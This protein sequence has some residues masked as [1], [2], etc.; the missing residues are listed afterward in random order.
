MFENIGGKIK[1][2]AK[3]VCWAGIIISVIAGIVMIVQGSEINNSYYSRGAG[4]SL[5][6]GGLMT[7]IIGS[8]LSWLGS[9]T[10][11][12]F[13]ELVENSTNCASTLEKQKRTIDDI[14]DR[15]SEIE[16][17]Q[18]EKNEPQEEKPVLPPRPTE[19]GPDT[20]ESDWKLSEDGKFVFCPKCG[21]RYSLDYMKYRDSCKECGYPRKKA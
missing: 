2:L 13:G 6:V 4:T 21:V 19:P 14:K 5:I 15:I 20:D 12:G 18:P 11:Y 16:K 10:L 17:K 7:M 3:F 8:L 9:L 1:G